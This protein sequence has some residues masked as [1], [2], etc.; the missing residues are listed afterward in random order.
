MRPVPR[1]TDPIPEA[2]A[3]NARWLIQLRWAQIVGQAATVLGA[4]VLLGV[5]LRLSWLW[6]LVA[7][8][9]G[10]NLA[11]AASVRRLGRADAR[12]LAAVMALDVA[13][14]TGLLYL[15][16]GATNPFGFL[17]LVQIALATVILEAAWAWALMALSFLGFGLLLLL[18]PRPLVVSPRTRAIGVWVALGVAAA[19]IVHFLQRVTAALAARE[20]ELA[21]ARNLAARQERLTSLATMAAGAAHELATPLGTVALVAKELERHLADHADRSLADDAR[22]IREQVGRCR[23]ILDQM[24][25]GTGAAGEGMVTQAIETLI[26]DAQA[27]I[28]LSPPVRLSVTAEVAATQM[29]LPARAVTQALRSLITNAQDASPA[30]GEVLLGINCRA[31]VV[32]IDVV[33]RGRGMSAEVLARIGEPFYTTKQP[34]RGMGL[35]LFLARAVFESVGGALAIDSREGAGTRVTVT[36][37]ADAAARVRRRGAPRATGGPSG[38]I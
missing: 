18:D 37:P 16:G 31:D 3:L 27:N 4:D 32:V 5:D 24:V 26:A 17:Y 28:R 1:R 19:F 14:L 21:E 35:G 15:T 10:S 6:A 34:G 36:M 38:G 22:L 33:D 8:G 20:A 30:D 12:L 9:L 29:T 2:S 13:A 11:L 25:G 7:I 23:G